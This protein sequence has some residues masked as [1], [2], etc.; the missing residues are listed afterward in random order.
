MPLKYTPVQLTVTAGHMRA[1]KTR[2]AEIHGCEASIRPRRTGCQRRG[3]HYRHPSG[4]SI[5]TGCTAR[6]LT[7]CRLRTL[8]ILTEYLNAPSTFM[9][10][11]PSS[12]PQVA[13]YQ[14]TKHPL[15]TRR[16]AY[17]NRPKCTMNQKPPNQAGLKYTMSQAIVPNEPYK[18]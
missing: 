18:I 6:G 16:D 4:V 15:R 12:K 3:C 10:C 14:C 11:W 13:A 7:A 5:T 17:Q 2:T 1:N 8:V 9:H